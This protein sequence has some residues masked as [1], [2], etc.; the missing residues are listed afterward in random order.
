MRHNGAM[1]SG[2]G[3]FI[4]FEGGEGTGKSTQARLLAQSLKRAGRKV[5]LTSEPGGT[6][7]GARIR[8]ILLT[9]HKEPLDP[10][11]EFFLFEAD[12]AEH[13]A[14]VIAPALQRGTDVI[15]DRFSGSTFAYQGYGQ[16]LIRLHEKEMEHIDALARRNIKP[17]LCILLDMDP[18]RAIARIKG[19]KNSLEKEALTFHK[20]VRSG[21]L[22]QARK[23]P[24]RWI[25]INAQHPIEE[26]HKKIWRQV[27]PLM[28]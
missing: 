10:M 21:F 6:A 7:R 27:E 19:A 15:C 11:T 9:K 13:V 22:A 26:I 17:D 2:Q 24:G 12:R 1:R 3:L 16:G 25:V 23:R 28:K 18:A 8:S 4:V 20:R 14:R 5:V